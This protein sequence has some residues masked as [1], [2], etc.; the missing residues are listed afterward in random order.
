M[1]KTREPETEEQ[2]S[3]RIEQQTRARSERIEI[4]DEALDAAIRRSIDLHG[5]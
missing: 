5:A 4:E 1:R 2:R 3:R